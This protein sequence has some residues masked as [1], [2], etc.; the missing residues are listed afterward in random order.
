LE[1]AIRR[2]KQLK[3]WSAKKKAAIIAGDATRLHDLSKCREL[4]GSPDDHFD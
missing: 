1:N 2:E 4:H 3:G